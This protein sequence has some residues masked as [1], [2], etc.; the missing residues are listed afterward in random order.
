[1]AN[2]I[3]GT[4][5]KWYKK[6][7]D[8]AWIVTIQINNELILDTPLKPKGGIALSDAL[9]RVVESLDEKPKKYPFQYSMMSE[10][11]LSVKTIYPTF[12]GGRIASLDMDNRSADFIVKH[13]QQNNWVSTLE[14]VDTPRNNQFHVNNNMMG[15]QMSVQNE[16]GPDIELYPDYVDSENKY[17]IFLNSYTTD[18]IS[19]SI[20]EGTINGY[21]WPEGETPPEKVGTQPFGSYSKAYI[22]LF[23]VG[24]FTP[25]VTS[26]LNKE[27]AKIYG[28]NETYIK[29]AGKEA[30][31]FLRKMFFESKVV[32]VS[33]QYNTQTNSL[34]PTDG[35]QVPTGIFYAT[36]YSNIHEATEAMKHGTFKGINMN[37]EML[38]PMYSA[39]EDV[40]TQTPRSLAIPLT[41]FT[42]FEEQMPTDGIL[43]SD[44]AQELDLNL[45]PTESTLDEKFPRDE[46]LN[47]KDEVD[48]LP[49][50]DDNSEGDLDKDFIG[51]NGDA[52]DLHPSK[53]DEIDYST[54]DSVPYGYLPNDLSHIKP[55]DDRLE[56]LEIYGP[57][58]TEEND[59]P[60][61]Y[62]HRVRIGDVFLSIPPLS[63]R[64]DKQFAHEKIKVMRAKTSLQKNIGNTR[65]IL[66]LE[67]Y[68]A[69][70]EDVNGVKRV[71]YSL[72]NGHTVHYYMDGLRPLIAQFKKAPFLPIDNDYVNNTLGVHNVILRNM[73]IQSVEGF[74]EA[75]QV[76]LILEE[77]DLQPMIIGETQLGSLV[78]YPL[79]RYHYQ[80][81]LHKSTTHEPYRTYLPPIEHLD[82][83]FTFTVVDEDKL[84]ERKALVQ[85]FRNMLTPHEFT[86]KLKDGEYDEGDT[87]EIVQEDARRINKAIQQ[88]NRYVEQGWNSKDL[89]KKHNI[90]DGSFETLAD[91]P[92]ATDFSSLGNSVTTDELNFAK[93]LGG[94]VYPEGSS[95]DS[96][97]QY[98]SIFIP[99]YTYEKR[100]PNLATPPVG[101]YPNYAPD[102]NANMML[103]YDNFKNSRPNKEMYSE[104]IAKK[105]N[106]AGN[107][108]VKIE[109]NYGKELF[110]GLDIQSG[111]DYLAKP[112]DD[113]KDSSYFSL[114]AGNLTE[115]MIIPGRNAD[116]PRNFIDDLVSVAKKIKEYDKR[117][118]AYED[119][120]N[121]LANRI[122]E[123]EEDMEM[124]PFYIPDFVPTNFTVSFENN[125]SNVQVQTATTPTFQFMGSSDPEVMLNF[126]T[127]EAGVAALEGLFRR[128]GRYTKEYREGIVSGFLGLENPMLR[129]LGIR[130]VIPQNVQYNTVPNHPDRKIVTLHLNSFDKTQRRQES[131]YGFKGANQEDN[132]KE[133][134]FGQYDPAKDSAF[135]QARMRQIE[136]YP[137]LELPRVAELIS[138]LPHL[139]AQIGN[140][141]PN[142]N[143]QV[144]L[145]PDFY[146]STSMTF[147][148]ILDGQINNDDDII[149]TEI[150][151][152]GFI[153]DSSLQ[154]ND[155]LKFWGSSTP[156]KEFERMSLSYYELAES[157]FYEGPE[158]GATEDTTPPADGSTEVP[159]DESTRGQDG[160]SNG[161]GSPEMSN[162]SIEEGVQTL[163]SRTFSPMTAGIIRPMTESPG[164]E[165]DNPGGQS[166]IG[167][168]YLTD[169]RN[170]IISAGGL[171]PWV[172]KVA[173]ILSNLFP[174]IYEI[175]GFRQGDPQDHGQGLALDP[176]VAP[177]GERL[178][179]NAVG[180]AVAKWAMDNYK[181]LNISYVIW[182]QKI[183]GPGGYGLQW[184]QMEDRGSNTQNHFDHVH[185]S[186]YSG[187]GN[188]A[189][190]RMPDGGS[191]GLANGSSTG[192]KTNA[193][194]NSMNFGGVDVPIYRTKFT[195]ITEAQ[196]NAARQKI[197]DFFGEDTIFL[198]RDQIDAANT[199]VDYSDPV[200]IWENYKREN[201]AR[202]VPIWVTDK[203][204]GS[205]SRSSSNT[206]GQSSGIGEAYI[207]DGITDL[208]IIKDF[209]ISTNHSGPQNELI[210]IT[211]HQT[212]GPGAGQD[213]L[214]MSNYQ[215]D[216]VHTGEQKSW[217]YQVD[218]KVAIQSFDHNI[219]CW[220]A[221]DGSTA[222][223]GNMATIG[224]ESCIN[225]D[226]DYDKAIINTVKLMASLCFMHGWNPSTDIYIHR[227]WDGKYCPEQILN[228]KNGTTLDDV[229]QM[230]QKELD[231]IKEQNGQGFREDVATYV[232]TN[233]SNPVFPSYQNWSNWDDNR[234]KGKKEYN[235]W[236]ESFKANEIDQEE[237]WFLIADTVIANFKDLHFVAEEVAS[238]AMPTEKEAID[239]LIESGYDEHYILDEK[240]Y[241]QQR[242]APINQFPS[243]PDYYRI[244]ARYFKNTD[245]GKKTWLNSQ[246][247]YDRAKLTLYANNPFYKEGKPYDYLRNADRP[248]PKL[249]G[250]NLGGKDNVYNYS[251]H[252]VMLYIRAL[253]LAESGG[254]ITQNGGP[255]F[256]K[257]GTQGQGIATNSDGAPIKGGLMGAK[258]YEAGSVREAERLLYDWRHNVR[259]VIKELAA[260]FNQA[261]KSKFKE[262]YIEAMDWAVVSRLHDTL[263]KIIWTNNS[264]DDTDTAFL[265]HPINP[266]YSAAMTDVEQKLTELIAAYVNNSQAEIL[267]TGLDGRVIDNVFAIYNGVIQDEEKL[268][269]PEYLGEETKGGREVPLS[270]LV[271][272]QKED[273]A[274]DAAKAEDKSRSKS[275]TWNNEEML[276]GMFVDMLEHDH[277]GRLVRAFPAFSL[278][279]IDEGK[280]YSNFKMWDNFYGYN[281]LQSID[282]YRSRKIAADTAIISMSN[283]YSGLSSK[284]AD[285]E[286]VEI[287]KPAFYSSQFWDTYVFNNPEVEDFAIRNEIHKSMMLEPGARIHLRMGYGSDTLRLPLVFN[288]TITEVD[289]QDVVTITAQG[290]ALELTNVISG[291]E[292]DQNKKFFGSITEPRDLIE[293]LL[294][295]KG[296]WIKNFLNV[297][298]KDNV[299][300]KENPLGIAHFGA[301]IVTPKNLLTPWEDRE[302]FQTNEAMQNV[303][304]SNGKGVKSQF[305]NEDGTTV[306]TFSG[307]LETLGAA[308]D[309]ISGDLTNIWAGDVVSSS[310]DESD[311]LLNLY[312]A[313]V[314]DVVQTF[315]MATTDYTAAVFPFE[316]RSSLFFGKTH[317]PVTYGYTSKYKVDL[318][319][320]AFNREVQDYHKKTFMQAHLANSEYNLIH[321]NMKVSAEGVYNNVI[322]EYDGHN[323]PIVQ[324]DSDIRSEQQRTALVTGSII[325]ARDGFFGQRN[326]YTSEV[327]ATSYAH[328]S[329]R[330][331]MKDMYKGSYIMMGDATIKPHDVM[332]LSDVIQD[333][334]G[335][336][337]V[338][339]VHQSM[340]IDSGFTTTIEPDAY[341]VNFDLEQ[342]FLIDKVF[343]VLKEGNILLKTSGIKPPVSSNGLVALTSFSLGSAVVGKLLNV[344][345]TWEAMGEASPAAYRLAKSSPSYMARTIE[346]ANAGALKFIGEHFDSDDIQKFASKLF[347]KDGITRKD[348]KDLKKATAVLKADW[349]ANKSAYKA[350]K[351]ALKNQDAGIIKMLRK[352]MFDLDEAAAVDSMVD[353]LTM[354]ENGPIELM[355]DF[356]DFNEAMKVA[357]AIDDFEKMDDI[358]KA[359]KQSKNFKNIGK[360][361]RTSK[362][363]GQSIFTVGK[364]LLTSAPVWGWIF[365]AT[366]QTVVN[367]LVEKWQRKKQ[368]S[369]AVKI[370]PLQYK[371]KAWLAGMTGHRGSVYGDSPSTADKWWNAHFGDDTVTGFSSWLPKIMNFLGGSDDSYKEYQVPDNRF[372]FVEG[373]KTFDNEIYASMPVGVM[374]LDGSGGSGAGGAGA[375]SGGGDNVKY[376]GQLEQPDA[377]LYDDSVAAA[378]GR[379]REPTSADGDWL[380]W[381]NKFH[382]LAADPPFVTGDYIDT[383][384]RTYYPK[385]QYSGYGNT[386][387]EMS[388]WF[389]ISAGMFLGVTAKE[390]TFGVNA[391][392]GAYNFGCVKWSEEY[393]LP[394]KGIVGNDGQYNEWIDPENI[395]TGIIFWFKYVRFRYI[396]DGLVTYAQFLDRYSP[397]SDN[398][399]HSQFK[400]FMWGALKAFGY[401]TADTMR[402]V[403]YSTGDEDPKT[404]VVEYWDSEEE[405]GSSGLNSGTIA[406]SEKP[407]RTMLSWAKNANISLIGDSLSVGVFN[408]L[409]K[410]TNAV[411]SR[412]LYN[413]SI[414]PTNLDGYR[415][416]ESMRRNGQIGTDMLIISLGTNGGFTTKELNDFYNRIPQNVKKVLFVTTNS[417]VGH[418]SKVNSQI[419]ILAS[420][421]KRV[422]YLD[423]E[424]FTNQKGRSDFY[425]VDDIHFT[426]AT[427]YRNFVVRG[428][429]NAFH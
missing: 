105:Y 202:N 196:Q 385:S 241:I 214:F 367:G 317:W 93:E 220:H 22:E 133:R 3:K 9:V 109:S 412:W 309:T 409:F 287:D 2:E 218:D 352:R 146:V 18:I 164:Q 256:S 60:W 376:N 73:Q 380:S 377:V 312:G 425:G 170:I 152:E 347:S 224:I 395:R 131:L 75:Y 193:T 128:V 270:G 405:S 21:Y 354:I 414:T 195:T 77:F 129:M 291:D 177:F 151:N 279:L 229:I 135:V 403:N 310:Q 84:M 17:W 115:D 149:T 373:K 7:H 294:T 102:P 339:A 70:K 295:S 315:A 255:V 349:K 408:D 1:M 420:K 227:D 13:A 230:T 392:G 138:A 274:E 158:E 413:A 275:P 384:L 281:A 428:A 64:M 26:S 311:V 245:M 342:L 426:N 68:F 61:D 386:I 159:A 53:D 272:S 300:F 375:G 185:I 302:E 174:G 313:T 404:F 147:R 340:N 417:K 113:D 401:D 251:F 24:S 273:L 233:K 117:I 338:K 11:D 235:A 221:G 361:A 387:K 391:C 415:T 328:A 298:S 252:R 288:G 42:G 286:H 368:N 248:Y 344:F 107:I 418:R 211:L 145:D 32:A 167:A 257:L 284:K 31:N 97:S 357:Q 427:P 308:W 111:Y 307:I 15:R 108:F 201:E 36:N 172:K 321:N 234:G 192:G 226:G 216:M 121:G 269:D 316:F 139:G 204:S 116:S 209:I 388:D 194:G 411:S 381:V 80:R 156:L 240:R 90:P 110:K 178:A 243:K 134:A 103:M 353:Y 144:Y 183:W 132:M 215:K 74:P 222:G 383:F 238:F 188:L 268:N 100:K 396:D 59:Y 163:S 25:G 232:A 45:P 67:A 290:D 319:T 126:E 374:R 325:A 244:E 87:Y 322:V 62:V 314:W 331:Y 334:Q 421:H 137:D 332:Y 210:G 19:G 28:V 95:G 41:E 364:K 169:K 237:L 406:T 191:L 39:F 198:S 94:I 82:N 130:Y 283:M 389:G 4:I 296:S 98:G 58:I 276:K 66:T 85:E 343:A 423:W 277:T 6:S 55:F 89:Q 10:R 52:T 249:F 335:V 46:T 101:P 265:G 419:K 394:M 318:A 351:K 285:M 337:L 180:D 402:K 362:T 228:A 365:N 407:S 236:I 92:I 33:L 29:R 16:E 119:K 44:W 429:Y 63:I 154:E 14:Y 30:Q 393:D 127:T 141:W 155:P 390:T 266:T 166:S 190:L 330:D 171:Q 184:T 213:A 259:K 223:G 148:N 301:P 217:H 49:I 320:G 76:T 271:D 200:L 56:S 382:L 150:D 297:V 187:D 260:I 123:T 112:E 346:K 356:A 81:S 106:F 264:D 8:T 336:H 69:S 71:G 341:V 118:E 231:F 122:N 120:Y 125:F 372:V 324:A 329:L 280:W 40:L 350:S 293:E 54:E 379:W 197:K 410:Y 91:V 143:K 20:V 247:Y 355:A 359:F 43:I 203:N 261:R 333:I 96:T 206:D 262:I 254:N 23:G 424:A 72:P 51:G 160:R 242:V 323:T 305:M 57:S 292:G 369:E 363:V 416:L 400:N 142:P 398:N 34:Q 208:E 345:S 175:G 246:D 99:T 173:I 366:M 35:Y 326:F 86:R 199:S 358:K 360:L 205:Y 182:E 37:K 168:D 299:L 124:K 161:G 212:G 181:D 253:I 370:I 304:S 348:V 79:L 162:Q 306:S 83:R 78:N 88:Y 263:P 48:D 47:P 371:G 27:K 157:N 258:L 104:H 239:A 176:M 186:F 153:V 165:T 303:Y 422:S 250:T 278:Q 327:Q 207:P 397:T 50:L 12:I 282:V 267:Y 399:D 378:A 38:R 65:N 136:L 289:A 140:T 225:S 189:G 5:L 179:K 219:R 114:P